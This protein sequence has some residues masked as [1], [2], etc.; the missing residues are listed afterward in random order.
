MNIPGLGLKKVIYLY[1]EHGISNPR[2]LYTF[3]KQGRLKTLS[4]FGEKSEKKIIG[5]LEKY[6]TQKKTF[7]LAEV[8]PFVQQIIEYLEGGLK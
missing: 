6:L 4:G 8:D 1:K 7:K 2:Q 3:A 5:F